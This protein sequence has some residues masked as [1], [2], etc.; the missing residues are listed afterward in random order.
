M[1]EKVYKSLSSSG[2]M[3]IVV[4]VLTIATGVVLGVLMIVSGSKLLAERKD[5]LI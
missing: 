2:V 4:G 1:E 3:G 5:V